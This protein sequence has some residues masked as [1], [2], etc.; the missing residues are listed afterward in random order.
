M[1]SGIHYINSKGIIHSDIKPENILID[2]IL[3][4]EYFRINSI[5]YQFI[6]GKIAITNNSNSVSKG[7]ESISA[8]SNPEIWKTKTIF[9]TP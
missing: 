2:Y 5:I 3:K 8:I 4:D 1:I 7:E 6:D 9:T